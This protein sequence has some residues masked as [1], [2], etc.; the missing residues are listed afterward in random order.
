MASEPNIPM[1]P[2]ELDQIDSIDKSLLFP[3]FTSQT[4]WTLGSALR[5]KLLAFAKP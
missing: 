3:G 5:T 1:P 2:R 4:A